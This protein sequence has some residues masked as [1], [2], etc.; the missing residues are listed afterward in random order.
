MPTNPPHTYCSYCGYKHVAPK[1]PKRCEGC[2]QTTWLNPTPVAVMLVPVEPSE[3]TMSGT[4]LV[5]IRRNIEPAKG[6]IALPSGF[7][8]AGETWQAAACR[9]LLEETGIKAAPDRVEFFR[10]LSAL[11]S[12]T[13]LLFCTVPA[14]KELPAFTPNEE[15]TE[16]SVIYRDSIDKMVWPGHR[17]MA[18]AYFNGLADRYER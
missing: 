5:T 4:G 10:P 3:P 8:D 11:D 12:N 14:I 17:M 15:V 9:E 13:I 16:L 1:F 7:I 18:T 6:R 2:G